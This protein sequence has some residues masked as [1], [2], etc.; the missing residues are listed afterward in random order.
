DGELK[1]WIGDFGLATEIAETGA[2]PGGVAGTPPFMAPELLAGDRASADRRSDVYSLGA[3]LFQL[4]TGELPPRGPLRW[5]ELPARAPA[6]PPDRA[7]IAARCLSADP[8][9]RYPSARAVAEDLHRFLDGE[10]VEAYADRLA[11]RLTRFVS[12]H[13][14]LLAVCGI[15]AL[16]LAGALAV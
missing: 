4:T 13:R 3:T 15:A 16:L 2:R 1:A 9:D 11:Y 5:P 14:T 8:E 10:V 6:R 12:R 7:A